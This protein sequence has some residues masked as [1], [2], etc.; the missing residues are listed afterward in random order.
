MKITIEKYHRKSLH[1]I[2][3]VTIENDHITAD[4]IED[5]INDFP[6][7]LS[8]VMAMGEWDGPDDYDWTGDEVYEILEK[9]NVEIRSRPAVG[10]WP[11]QGADTYV[12]GRC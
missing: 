2:G 12:A 1:H 4:E 9:T 6:H 3:T 11:K 5:I 7:G 10:T 8:G